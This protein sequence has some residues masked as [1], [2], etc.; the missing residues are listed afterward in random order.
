VL[1]DVDEELQFH[2]EM[3]LE[4]L[5]SEGLSEAEARREAGR[6][7]GDLTRVR[8]ECR[9]IGMRREGEMR[10]V[11]MMG[12][13]RQDV[14]F[15]FRQLIKTPGASALAVLTLALGIG[16]TTVVFSVV[17]AIVLEAVPFEDA[18]EIVVIR[19]LTPQGDYF[20][21]SDPN[22]LDW[23][24][25]QRSF[26]DI[27]A[28]TL[29][30]MTLTGAGEAERVTGFRASHGLL[31][32]LRIAPIQ[33]RHFAPDED[34]FETGDRV[35]LLA[36]GFWERRFARDETLIGESLELD[37]EP[38]VVVGVV[39]TDRGFPE[40]EIFT[41]LRPDPSSDRSN[42]MLQ[43]VGR[44]APSI[45]VAEARLDMQRIGGELA[46]E[47]PEDNAGW[48]A[49]VS[50]FSEW[51][52]GDRL[53]R[54]G[55]FLMLAVGLL[56]LMAC[57][58]VSTMLIARATGRQKEMGLRAAL[59]AGRQRIVGQLITES[60][61]LGALGGG[62]GVLLAWMGTPAV[63]AL[64]PADMARLG[65]ASIDGR[66]LGVALATSVLSVVIFGLAPALFATRG[67]LFDALR[68]GAP[69][70]PGGHRRLRDALVVVQFALAIVVVLGAG[71]MTR[72]F[73][74]VQAVDLGFR[75]EGALQFSVGVPDG[76]FS[77]NERVTFLEQ[78]SSQ[79]S[80]LPG[81]EA[82][83]ITM[84]GP[85][86]PFQASNFVA[87]ADD[88]PDRQDDFVPVSWRAVD[89]GFFS[90]AG[91]QLIAGRIFTAED[92]PPEDEEAM[93]KGYEMS[94]ILDERLA[95]DIWGTPDAVGKAVVWNDPA[96]PTMRVVGVVSSIRD[97]W[98]QDEPRPRIYLPYAV[99]PWPSPVVLVRS[100]KDPTALVPAI[101][102]LVRS[103]D[104]DV[105]V[106][107]VATLPE[108]TRQAVAW[109]R[110]TMQVVSAFGL[111]AVIL[112]A[113]G[114]YGVASFGVLRRRREIGIRVA[115]GAD[116]GRVVGLV[117]RSALRLAVVGIVLGVVLAFGASGFLR[118]LLY[119]IEPDDPTTFIVLPVALGLIA[120]LASWLPAR[121]ATRVDAREAL[122]Q[123]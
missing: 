9:R 65:E 80:G 5:R 63:R 35:V 47:Y 43:A 17:N 76:A 3:R 2:L 110:F 31:P 111:V 100:A 114:I 58:S 46:A 82:V 119:G 115:L 120:V 60:A 92:V 4:D 14:G 69:S 38:H 95:R 116:P 75:P 103:L 23:V 49:A 73:A 78:L 97:E 19:E 88:V 87:P 28:Y 39:P 29:G 20:S 105:P 54:I 68:E 18:D 66:V 84:S 72:S 109:P 98:V 106:M 107:E 15:A 16:A 51:R 22:Y 79:I 55:A 21:T 24:E 41:P 90:A 93:A 56:L 91:V 108:V 74:R 104:A 48:S 112:A 7:F 71:L 34:R 85:F 13:L 121:R 83:G 53:E 50:P 26:T 113:M 6:Q 36:E 40:A 77:M 45:T 118:T 102:A 52:V 67:R 101:R 30:D 11:D 42:H 96:G 57:G 70:V 37:G 64:G 86:S 62:L 44:L 25:R 33:G 59:G 123:E 27:G 12:A 99:F 89:G 94:V 81:V 10:F 117:L 122:A 61:V 32:L 8:D 1:R